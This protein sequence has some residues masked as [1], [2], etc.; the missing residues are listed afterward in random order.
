MFILHRKVAG[1]IRRER[2]KSLNDPDSDWVGFTVHVRVVMDGFDNILH[3]VDTH[4]T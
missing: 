1:C 2:K 4:A 3:V